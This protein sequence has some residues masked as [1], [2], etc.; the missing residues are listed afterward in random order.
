M[1]EQLVLCALLNSF[2]A[3]YLVRLRVNTHVTVSL[4]SRLP[5]PVLRPGDRWF[6]QLSRLSDELATS[7][8]AIES[9]PAYAE[10]QAIA[11]H[12]FGLTGEEFAHVLST[13]PLVEA[14]AR[15]RSLALFGELRSG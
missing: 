14:Q 5:L 11:A 13:F 8:L 1:E 9:L 7:S 4:V 6:E 10:L 2:V 12:L 15:V 3:N